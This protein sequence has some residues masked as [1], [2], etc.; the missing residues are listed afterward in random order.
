MSRSLK[1]LKVEDFW[2]SKTRGRVELM[3]NRDD[4]VFFAVIEHEKIEAPSINELRAKVKEALSKLTQV[5]WSR[6]I[7]LSVSRRGGGWGNSEHIDRHQAELGVTFMRFEVGKTAGGINLKRP[8]PEDEH[9]HWREDLAANPLMHSSSDYDH[10]SNERIPYSEAAWT[11][12]NG[13][14][15]AVEAAY[16]KLEPLFDAKDKGAKLLALTDV[17]L[18]PANTEV[19]DA[20]PTKK[21]RKR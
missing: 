19:V 16:A 10:E 15:A 11:A 7:E 5:E 6:V 2:D 4:K 21:A 20:A 3:L 9:E 17:R 1:P 12:L 14:K 8:F 18:L 13:V